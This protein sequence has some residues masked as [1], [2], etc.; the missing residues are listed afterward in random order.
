MAIVRYF[1][2]GCRKAVSF[3]AMAAVIYC[4]LTLIAF[5]PAVSFRSSLNS[6]LD[7]S[8]S[9]ESLNSGFDFT[10]LGD[11]VRNHGNEL[12]ASLGGLLPALALSFIVNLFFAGGIIAAA[13]SGETSVREFFRSCAEY[14][15]RFT[16]LFLL[17]VGIAVLSL[18]GIVVLLMI[19]DTA[20]TGGASSEDPTFWAIG[21]DILVAGILLYAL[22]LV[23]DYTRIAIVV[24]RETSVF[25]SLKHS[26]AFLWSSKFAAGGLTLLMVLVWAAFF[27][28]YL[29]IEREIDGSATAVL[30]GLVILQ[31]LL[32]ASRVVLRIAG[33][34]A[35]TRLYQD[36]C[37]AADNRVDG[38]G[39]G[40]MIDID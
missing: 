35:E 37:H 36:R 23:D 6:A 28:V 29:A 31:Q 7:A 27:L 38:I 14:M 21:L 3:R 5:I 4:A 34:G 19:A 24:E 22:S 25:Q 30:V 10:V 15:G 39:M 40:V 33:F 17:M 26:L 32:V 1:L 8:L 13:D 16:R 11:I 20:I 9:A 18:I 2:E 12:T